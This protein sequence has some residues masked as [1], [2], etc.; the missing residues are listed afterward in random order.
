MFILDAWRVLVETPAPAVV[1]LGKNT[2]QIKSVGSIFEKG[3]WCYCW[4][5]TC[6]GLCAIAVAVTFFRN[7]CLDNVPVLVPVATAPAVVAVVAM[8]VVAVAVVAVAVSC[9]V[10]SPMALGRVCTA[11]PMG[12]VYMALG[13]MCMTLGGVQVRTL[14]SC[15]PRHVTDKTADCDVR[16]L[17]AKKKNAHVASGNIDVM[18]ATVRCGRQTAHVASDL[19]EGSNRTASHILSILRGRFNIERPR[20]EGSTGV[21][22]RN[23]Y[24]CVH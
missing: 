6:Q 21:R 16:Y 10:L 5:V 20:C 7:S 4:C 12:G 11:L 2:S 1:V 22:R 15:W 17:D 14:S 24:L 18:C 9:C 19:E 23:I 3:G 13:S 8:A